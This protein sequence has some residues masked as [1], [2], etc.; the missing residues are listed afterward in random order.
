MSPFSFDIR[1]NGVL[2]YRERTDMIYII[3]NTSPQVVYVPAASKKVEGTL[4]FN[5]RST[6]DRKEEVSV[7]VSQQGTSDL[8]YKFTLTLSAKLQNGEYEY[9]L[10]K[11]NDTLDCGLAVVGIPTFETEYNESIE[12]EQYESE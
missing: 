8:Y 7:S 10:K 11:G 5:L 12:Y 9:V 6:V 4:T 2:Y 1:K 3:N